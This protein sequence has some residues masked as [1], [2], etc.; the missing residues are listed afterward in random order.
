MGYDLKQK[1]SRPV[2]PD[3]PVFANILMDVFVSLLFFFFLSQQDLIIE[4]R[5]ASYLRQSCLSLPA[6]EMTGM[7]HP[8]LVVIMTTAVDVFL[9][10][11]ETHTIFV[12]FLRCVYSVCVCPLCGFVRCLPIPVA[13]W[14]LLIPLGWLAGQ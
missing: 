12:N 8:P 10:Y 3:E 11:G 9:N 6:A 2:T 14:N 13:T 5:L 4:N 7:P 1:T